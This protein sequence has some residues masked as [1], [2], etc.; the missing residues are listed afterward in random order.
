MAARARREGVG[1]EDRA[2]VVE[3]DEIFPR[4]RSERCGMVEAERLC[5]L[6]DRGRVRWSG[7]REARGRLGVEAF[8]PQLQTKRQ[9]VLVQD[10]VD[11]GDDGG[12]CD[13]PLTAV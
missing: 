6:A 3:V 7:V 2:F 8:A 4:E 13:R 11:A 12:R 1:D 10:R 9:L 5:A